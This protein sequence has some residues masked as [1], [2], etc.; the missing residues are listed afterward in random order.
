MSKNVFFVQ[1]GPFLLSDLFVNIDLNKKIKIFDIKPLDEA[2]EVDITFL[3][4]TN[5]INL[6]KQTKAG[7]CLTTD[8][9]KT[10]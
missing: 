5:Y 4:S 7:Y 2:S 10:H 3:E 9:L 8:K 6:A 1:K